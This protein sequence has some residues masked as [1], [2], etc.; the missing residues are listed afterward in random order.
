MIILIHL[1]LKRPFEFEVKIKKPYNL[2][3]VLLE[4]LRQGTPVQHCQSSALLVYISISSRFSFYMYIRNIV[5]ARVH[6]HPKQSVRV[7]S[8]TGD[9]APH[10][11]RD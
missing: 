5:S 4:R 7:D 9:T 1:L 3:H 8:G 2:L 10:V 6:T 11:V